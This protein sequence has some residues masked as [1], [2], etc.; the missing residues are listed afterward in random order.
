MGVRDLGF[1]RTARANLD[2]D[3]F[4]AGRASDNGAGLLSP[5]HVTLGEAPWMELKKPVA[6]YTAATNLE[7][8]YLGEMLQSE[9]I[10]AAVVED[11]SRAGV[12]MFG[13]LPQIHKPKIWVEQDDAERAR[14]L[15]LAEERRRQEPRDGGVGPFI[16]VACEVCR[17][18]TMFPAAE[19][20]RVGTCSHCGEFVDVGEDE[21]A[22]WDVG[23]PE[24]A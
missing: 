22:T 6:V 16:A 15:I 11:E 9:G 23:Q 2:T 3:L 10:A 21:S 7:A 17:K 8:H 13:L 12:W 1:H 18:T 4:K 14:A 24:D 20:G 19:N 5:F